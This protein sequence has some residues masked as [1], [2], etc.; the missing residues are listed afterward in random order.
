MSCHR[1]KS[2][3]TDH[4]G[5]HEM[6]PQLTPVELPEGVSLDLF[7]YSCHPN[8]LSKFSFVR[9]SP[10]T[11]MRTDLWVWKRSVGQMKSNFKLFESDG[12][13]NALCWLVK[14]FWVI[15]IVISKSEVIYWFERKFVFW[16]CRSSLWCHQSSPDK[17]QTRELLTKKWF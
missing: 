10:R 5:P 17:N 13:E 14:I 12:G 11:K 15:A 4:E 9:R 6:C 16:P 1:I 3:D 7:Q 8:S 2:C